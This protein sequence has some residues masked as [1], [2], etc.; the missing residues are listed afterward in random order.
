MP[1]F[2][3]LPTLRFLSKIDFTDG[4]QHW[5]VLQVRHLSYHCFILLTWNQRI[6][7]LVHNIVPPKYRP[8]LKA[9][10]LLSQIYVLATFSHQTSSRIAA[11]RGLINQFS[12]LLPVSTSHLLIQFSCP[13]RKLVCCVTRIS[14]FPKFTTFNTCLM[15]LKTRVVHA[16]TPPNLVK[17]F[18]LGLLMHIMHPIRRMLQLM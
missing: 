9:I 11:G 12:D 1:R 3:N 7:P 4:D 6:L 2:P 18:M 16:S 8:L 15:I 13:P 17:V 14:I 10:R 5:H